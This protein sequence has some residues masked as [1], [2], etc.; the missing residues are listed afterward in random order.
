MDKINR[1]I[2]VLNEFANSLARP[3]QQN[4]N[5][6]GASH[7]LISSKENVDNFFNFIE[8]FADKFD[9]FSER[10][11][12]LEKEIRKLDEQIQATRENLNRLSSNNYAETML[13]ERLFSDYYLKI[14]NY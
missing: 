9:T 8:L 3:N 13:V 2:N 6:N 7:Q 4:N 1:Q 11:I 10:R 5:N 14:Y 12:Q